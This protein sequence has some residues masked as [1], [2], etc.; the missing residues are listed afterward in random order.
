MRD[1]ESEVIQYLMDNYPVRRHWLKPGVKQVT[2]EWTLQDDFKFSP[3]DAHDFLLDVFEHFNIE[4]SGFDG[5]NYFEYE[6]PFWQHAP[7]ERELKPLTVEM[8][9]KSAKAG[10]WLYE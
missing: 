2:K 10:H 4:H 8:I 1:F 9:V 5:T 6:Y 3:E 7:L